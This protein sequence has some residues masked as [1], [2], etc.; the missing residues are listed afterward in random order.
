M[1]LKDRVA[2]VT[3]GASGCGR[4]SAHL[5]AKEGAKVLVADV[6]FEE[7]NRVADRIRALGCDATAMKVNI[8]HLDNVEKMVEATLNRYGRIDVLVNVAGGSAGPTIDTKPGP[9]STSTEESREEMVNLNLHGALNCTRAVIN[10]MIE[11]RSGKVISFASDCGM[12]GCQNAVVYSAA[13][14]GVIG[15]TKALAKEVAQYGINVNCISPG[16]VA[17]D[18]IRALPK[19]YMEPVIK[20]IYWGRMGEPDELANAVLFLA[21]DEASYITGK[22]IVVDGGLTLGFE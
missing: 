2:I 3:G 5:L 17:S 12:M 15:F 9:F 8:K 1:R 18:R 13:K 21:S 4:S 16:V 10:H 11:R 6:Q 22:N 19:D 7:A 20:S 14:A